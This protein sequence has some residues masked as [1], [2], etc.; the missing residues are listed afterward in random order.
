MTATPR[1]GV[2]SVVYGDRPLPS[3][4]DDLAALPIDHLELWDAHLAPGD[5]E[6]AIIGAEGTL[7]EA[8]VDVVGYG[9]VD[10]TT[11]GEVRRYADLADRLG[12]S[13]LTVNYPP[14][15]DDVTEELLWAA[16]TF[17]LDVA[18]HNYSTVHHDDVDSIFSSIDD[19]ASVLD[20]F[21]DPRLGA[22]ID[23]GHF[24]VMDE[25]PERALARLP[26][27]IH[28]V[29][30]K[31]TS[32]ATP[33]DVPG[34]GR[35]DLDGVLALLAEHDALDVPLIIEYEMEAARATENLREADR[36][37]RAALERTV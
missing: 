2:Q 27:R 24:L 28:A 11:I 32:E 35:L 15:R 8:G 33:E 30:L 18:I 4:V 10:L 29:H 7:G 26:E 34:A 17:D 31:D 9:V 14:D 20:R 37:V 21:E 3:F 16:D 22:C 6:E 36:N 19:V 13:Y 23:T 25:P 5:G 12:A 1:L